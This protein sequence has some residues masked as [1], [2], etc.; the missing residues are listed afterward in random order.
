VPE[1]LDALELARRDIGISIV[2]LWYFYFGLGGM[3]TPLE[4]DAF[5]NGALVATTDDRDLLAV[6][7]NERYAENGGD[8]PLPYS[9]DDPDYR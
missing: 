8:H 2:D 7:L 6:A 9:S 3:G 4:I 5:L 1:T